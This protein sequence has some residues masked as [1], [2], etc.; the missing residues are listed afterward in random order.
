MSEP[1]A[2]MSSEGLLILVDMID[3]RDFT[4]LETKTGKCSFHGILQSLLEK[5]CMKCKNLDDKLIKS[6]KVNQ[7]AIQWLKSLTQI[8]NQ[9]ASVRW[10]SYANFET[11][12]RWSNR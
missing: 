11:P 12:N 5:P 6:L 3:K 4:T 2:W 10:S 9:I 7:I 1:A 8:A